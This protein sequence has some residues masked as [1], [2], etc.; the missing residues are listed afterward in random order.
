MSFVLLSV[1]NLESFNKILKKNYSFSRIT[2][3]S[4]G[5]FAIQANSMQENR[6][7]VPVN[8]ASIFGICSLTRFKPYSVSELA[9]N[10]KVPSTPISV[11]EIITVFVPFL[12]RISVA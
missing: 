7:P 9:S 2:F 8:M 1:Q 11:L 12:W 4:P 5:N 10:V 6:S 3:K